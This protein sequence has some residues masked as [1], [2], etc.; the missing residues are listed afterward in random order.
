MIATTPIAPAIENAS[1]GE[2]APARAPRSGPA[3]APAEST[4]EIVPIV[5]ER[6]SGTV[7]PVS[8]AIAA[9][10]P[11]PPPMPCRSR[12]M[13][14]TSP[15][16][17]QANSA[18]A[19]TKKD[20]PAMTTRRGPTRP[21]IQPAGMVVR[22]KVIGYEA[23]RNATSKVDKSKRLA[24]H[25]NSGTIARYSSEST[26]IVA[27]TA[28]KSRRTQKVYGGL[29]VCRL[30]PIGCR[31]ESLE[32]YVHA[33]MFYS[34]LVTDQIKSRR[35]T[36]TIR[37]GDKSDK[38]QKGMI[39][40]VL[41]GQR[42]GPRERAFDAVIDKVEVKPLGDVSPREIQHENAQLRTLDEFIEFLRRLYN[43]EVREGD[44]VT[45]IHFSEIR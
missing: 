12:A 38:Y 2:V 15:L 19:N 21:A 1:T 34:P 17:A 29:L 33:L 30:R 24:Y 16:G 45:V 43:R 25:G 27:E 18:V 20:V 14:I 5:R 31:D 37:L 41:I 40:A 35:K 11:T 26:N 39:V 4:P 6:R 28:K 3:T 42:F 8:H 36:V 9:A 32:A 22:R 23:S 44:T 13:M 10:Q 7:L